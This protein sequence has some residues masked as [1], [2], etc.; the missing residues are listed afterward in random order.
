MSTLSSPSECGV[1]PLFPRETTHDSS[2]REN[3]GNH[4]DLSDTIEQLDAGA[5]IVQIP[6]ASHLV[7]SSVPTPP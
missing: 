5:P 7:S 1:L 3:A 4:T 2:G 6:N